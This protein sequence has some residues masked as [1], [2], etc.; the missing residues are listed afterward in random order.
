MLEDVTETPGRRDTVP[1]DQDLPYTYFVSYL[2]EGG[3]GNM[4]IDQSRPMRTMEDIRGVERL[5]AEGA[6]KR[7]CLTNFV[8]L[9]EPKRRWWQRGKG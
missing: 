4:R 6:G 3:W 5:A 2:F 1:T 9:S 7:V 8:L